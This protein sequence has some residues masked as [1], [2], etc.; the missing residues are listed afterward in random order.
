MKDFT[1]FTFPRSFLSE[2]QIFFLY[3]DICHGGILWRPF[4]NFLKPG[5]PGKIGFFQRKGWKRLKEWREVTFIKGWVK[6]IYISC[7]FCRF[8]GVN[9]FWN[10]VKKNAEMVSRGIPKASCTFNQFH[11]FHQF[12]WYHSF[13]SSGFMD[14]II[15]IHSIYSF[16]TFIFLVLQLRQAGDILL[17]Y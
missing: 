14:S 1:N 7:L 16:M 10:K 15:S 2:L 17:I 6:P 9:G 11:W 4:R 3:L 5:K 8:L 13:N 12:N